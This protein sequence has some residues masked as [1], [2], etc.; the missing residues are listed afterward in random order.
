MGLAPMF[1]A[2]LVVLA[3]CQ[4]DPSGL[5]DTNDDMR[6]TADASS[7]NDAQP[8][9]GADA[10]ACPADYT[11]S[12]I[13]G[14]S[15]HFVASTILWSPAEAACETEGTHLVVITGAE[16]RAEVLRIAGKSPVGTIDKIWMGL[17]DRKSEG[18]WIF[19]TGA[20]ASELQLNWNNGEP[21]GSADCTAFYR[22]NELAPDQAGRYDDA[23][24]G[25][26]FRIAG[27]MCECDGAAADTSAY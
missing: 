4:F 15:Y 9:I 13:T 25:D 27:Y 21:N 19:V 3:G 22:A 2:S 23:A 5:A 11:P 7:I 10:T 14:T 1:W 16:E 24:C 17:T 18:I 6:T 20:P 8:I 12:A 26:L